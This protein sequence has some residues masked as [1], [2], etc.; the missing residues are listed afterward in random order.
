MSR[1][2]EYLALSEVRQRGL[3][4]HD[5][6]GVQRTAGATFVLARISLGMQVTLTVILAHVSME[7]VVV[8]ELGGAGRRALC[9]HGKRLLSRT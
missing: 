3:P 1:Y 2:G 7:R 4:S 9:S 6:L 5:H 8:S